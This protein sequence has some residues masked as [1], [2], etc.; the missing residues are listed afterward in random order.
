MLVAN[1][2]NLLNPSPLVLS[3]L[4]FHPISK[5][6]SGTLYFLGF[7]PPRF[8]EYPF[9]FSLTDADLIL[10]KKKKKLMPIFLRTTK[11]MKNSAMA[12]HKG[13]PHERSRFARTA[14]K[15]KPAV[16]VPEL[17]IQ[18]PNLL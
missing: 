1:C 8:C 12:L 13:E 18:I 10:Q 5:D 15:V 6:H 4:Q 9:A 14:E 2:S 11:Q 16:K 17:L 7:F 3:R